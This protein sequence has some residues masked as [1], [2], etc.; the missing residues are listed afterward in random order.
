MS[1]INS[2]YIIFGAPQWCKKNDS[3]LETSTEDRKRWWSHRGV[4]TNSIKFFFTISI[5]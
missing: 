2:L 4:K 5:I 1:N 3:V